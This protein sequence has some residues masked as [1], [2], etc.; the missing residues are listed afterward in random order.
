ME[1]LKKILVIMLKVMAIQ[2]ILAFVIALGWLFIEISKK[3]ES[4]GIKALGIAFCNVFF[5]L[6]ILCATIAVVKIWWDFAGLKRN[7]RLKPRSHVTMEGSGE[8][9]P[10]MHDVDMTM[11]N[12][13]IEV[14]E[15][16][17]EIAF[18]LLGIVD[19]IISFSLSMALISF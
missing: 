16:T 15:K 11:D 13:I 8:N 10:M 1:R 6:G 9:L 18:I 3:T 17:W 19:F 2:A 5:M 4:I 7:L 12:P 14:K